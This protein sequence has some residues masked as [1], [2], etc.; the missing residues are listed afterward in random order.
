MLYIALNSDSK[1]HVVS[2]VVPGPESR[3]V[4]TVC[5][6]THPESDFL[7]STEDDSN[8]C[9]RCDSKVEIEEVPVEE[10]VDTVTPTVVESDEEVE[11]PVEEK[12]VPKK[13]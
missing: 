1:T 10:P 3:V 2:T 4:T 7:Y 13:K 11:E 8:L 5:G 9:S 12:P 6:L